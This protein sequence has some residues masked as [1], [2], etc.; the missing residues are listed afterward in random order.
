M[1]PRDLLKPLPLILIVLFL[2]LAV[3]DLVQTL[4]EDPPTPEIAE[5]VMLL[6]QPRE[7]ILDFRA[8]DEPTAI[9]ILP[10]P[11]FEPEQWSSA[12]PRGVW[13]KGKSAEFTLDLA[14]GGYR[15]LVLECLPGGGKRPVHSVRVTVNQ[16]DCGEVELRP[17]LGS[18]RV[19]LP[20]A[21][22]R[23]GP[24]KLVFSFKDREKARKTRR[25]LLIR[26]IALFLEHEADLEI[27]RTSRLMVLGDEGEKIAFNIAGTLDV[28]LRLDD[29]TDAL[30]MNY[31]FTSKLG[32]AEV[33]VVQMREG[34][35]GAGDAVRTSVSAEGELTGHL[36]VPLHGR[37]GAYV[38]RIRA[39]PGEPG[40]RL[41][42][43]ALRLTEEGDPTGRP[44]SE[45]PLR[46]R[47]SPPRCRGE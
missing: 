14:A 47:G 30:R 2:A 34:Q 41:L 19:A 5:P 1:D 45:N 11:E 28:P 36:R 26:R 22:T 27:P 16:V 42:I 29:R 35:V 3:G 38:L 43:S 32:R 33:A 40:A 24:N 8:T 20:E 7:P 39:T 12:T 31:R 18:Y 17:G 25:A 13:A 37:R 46:N 6:F 9:A 15:S 10:I 23:F 4:T 44:W 21:V